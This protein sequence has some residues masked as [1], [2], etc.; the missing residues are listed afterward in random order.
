MLH[1]YGRFEPS[2]DSMPSVPLTGN[3]V[4]FYLRNEVNSHLSLRGFDGRV[5]LARWDEVALAEELKVVD[6]GLH[7]LLHR[8]AGWWHQL[9]VVNADGA[10]GNL[11]QTLGLLG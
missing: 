10:L 2:L 11:V 7:A 4:T 5:S 3:E 8:S 6:K 1:R 9:V